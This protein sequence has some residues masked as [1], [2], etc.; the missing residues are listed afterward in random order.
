MGRLFSRRG[1]ARNLEKGFEQGFAMWTMGLKQRR[2][3]EERDKDRELRKQQFEENQDRLEGEAHDQ[4]LFRME[5]LAIQGK[6][7][8]E[9]V[10]GNKLTREGQRIANEK[11][12]RR[13]LS[14]SRWGE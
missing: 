2:E 11:N 6:Q 13:L 5:Q 12:N 3:E 1:L 8:E 7:L 14:D 9:T 4:H 10:L